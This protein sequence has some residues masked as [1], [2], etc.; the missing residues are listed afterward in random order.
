MTRLKAGGMTLPQIVGLLADVAKEVGLFGLGITEHTPWDAIALRKA[1]AELLWS[2][3]LNCRP[4]LEV[5]Q[6]ARTASR[7]NRRDL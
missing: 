2:A 6:Q 3:N 4:E 1:L 5:A 7:D